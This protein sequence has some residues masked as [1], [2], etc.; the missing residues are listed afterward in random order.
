[1]AK[2][3]TPAAVSERRLWSGERVGVLL[4]LPLAGTYDYRIPRGMAL[5]EGDFV[6]VPFG[7]R[8]VAGVV[9]GPG[10][11]GVGEDRLKDVLGRCDTPPLPPES[12]RFVHWVSGYTVQSPGS[13]LKMVMSVPEALQPAKPAIAYVLPRPPDDAV[14]LTPARRRVLEVLADGPPRSAAEL[15]REA[16][17]GPSVIKGLAGAGLIAAVERW[18]VPPPAPDW[19]RPG[20]ALSPAQT[21]AA[22]GLR[23]AVGGGFAVTLV[24]GV[25]GSGKTE[26]YF[27][28]IAE[29]LEQGRQALVLLPEIALGAQWLDRFRARFAADP[30]QWH[31][32]LG[33]GER[34]RTW[35]A[36]AEGGVP[37]VVGARSALFLP[38]RD[39]G[40]IVVD[41]EHDPAFKQDD[42]VAYNA[43]DMAV[44]RARLGD[45]PIAL[46]SATPSLETLVNVEDGR[47]RCVHLPDRHAG[48]A[49]PTITVVDQRVDRPP[50]GGWLSPTLRDA[51]AETVSGGAQALL[52]LNRRGYAPLT[53]C[54]ACGHRLRC[55]WCTAWLVEH[56]LIG[57]LQCHHC[58]YSAPLPDIC[59]ACAAA[60]SLAACGPG[61]ERLAEEVADLFPDF[62]RALATSD[63]LT[64]PA[65][66][67]DLVR[68]IEAHEIDVVI[69]TQIVAKGYHF[70]LLTL[71]GVVDADLGL[72][73]GDLRAAERT[74]QLLY[75]VAGRAGRAERPGRVVLQTYMPEH[76]VMAA[77]VSG[78]RARFLAAETEAR[79]ELRMPPFGRLAAL[80]VSGRDEAAVDAAAR[81]L[82]RAAPADD[83]IRVLGPAPAPLSLLR[84]RHRRRL[85]LIAAKDVA[86]PTV[87]RRWLATVSLPGS[88]RV[89]VDVDPLSFL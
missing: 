39:L 54:R 57:R 71:V 29:A 16:G 18:P 12:R 77:L 48:A 3:V 21:R 28:A 47:Y 25:P 34:R 42:G 59:P 66:A 30:A 13:V 64:G 80:I 37:V 74:Y 61:V 10:S 76:P 79:R 20:P 75:Q 36:V 67:R 46:V 11:D 41:E 26:V 7:A 5:S 63:T 22:E 86:V 58:G 82:G 89:Q 73:G 50:R 65:A 23:R 45:A 35:R 85:L 6:Q 87:I 60:D 4:P 24:D 40:L 88:V 15:A 38:F 33:R 52:F 2:T 32:E 14:R 49:A 51:L 78:D 68:R 19:R 55:P 44:V 83:G 8:Q 43:R 27:E 9:W 17:V 56:R 84:G 72:T 1:M 81:A 53:L 69:G 62:R 31:S 70:P